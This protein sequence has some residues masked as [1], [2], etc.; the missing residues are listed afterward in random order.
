MFQSALDPDVAARLVELASA[1]ARIV[2]VH[3]TK[4][5]KQLLT[6]SYTEHERAAARTPG[7]DGR[8]AELAA[9]VTELLALP[10]VTEVDDAADTVEALRALGVTGRAEFVAENRS[11]LSHLREDG[12]LL[13]L[14]VYQ[15]LY[16]TEAATRLEVA[17]PGEGTVYR[18]DAW[19]GSL[20]PY[21]E[22]RVDGGRTIVSI[23]LAPG[24]TALFTLDR[25]AAPAVAAPTSAT[26]TVTVPVPVPVA[27]LSEWHI[28]VES[29]DAG[30]LQTITEDRGLGYTS[31]EVRPLTAVTRLDAGSG[32]L[33]PWKDIPEVGP[34]VS[35][36]G[37]YSTEFTV[38]TLAE[39]ARYV[40]DLGSTSGGLGSVR[41]NG[42]DPRGFDTSHPVVD[43]TDD[44]R[45]GS[46]TVV[47][48]VASSLNN[49]LLARGYYDS[50]PDVFAEI[51]GSPEAMQR[52]VV[53]DHGLVGPVTLQ[54]R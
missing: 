2:L 30:E 44:L 16:E 18:I 1:G 48:R 15:F 26:R 52:T 38:E 22:T 53:R 41:I 29:W 46:N 54:R 9:T 7:L 33:R 20:Q 21:G 50:V 37:E 43:V 45:T 40:L 24:E 25:S 3:G 49:R 5:L 32:A 42:A 35:G 34:S 19:S 8:D 10:T 36:V 27:T 17:L 13:H 6:N 28:A 23:E 12:D 51:T 39:G 4:E 14:Y 47:V 31:R 11:V